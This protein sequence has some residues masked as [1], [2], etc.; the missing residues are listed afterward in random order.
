MEI[1]LFYS[2][3]TKDE[4]LR[5]EL[6]KA[7][8]MLKRLDSING[9]N[10]RAI[11]PGEDWD[12]EINKELENSDIILL[13]LSNDFL[14]SDYCYDVEVKK[15]LELHN[16][17]KAIAIPVIL[18]QCD[19]KH[20]NSPLKKLEAIPKD[21]VPVTLWSNPDIAFDDIAQSLKGV[22]KKIK[23]KKLKITPKTIEQEDLDTIH[24]AIELFAQET[25]RLS[26][27][28]SKEEFRNFET[29]K[30]KLY[31]QLIGEA[32]KKIDNIPALKDKLS[33]LLFEKIYT[34]EE[35]DP[36][37]TQE[38]LKFRNDRALYKWYER[39]VIVNAIALSIIAHKKF[40]RNKANLLIDF[41]SDFEDVVWQTA[42][43]GLILS[44]LYHQN[45]WQR[46]EDFKA[47]LQTLKEI[48]SVQEGL[49]DIEIIIRNGLFDKSI[50]N[51]NIYSHDFFKSP[52]NCFLPFYEN[53][54]VLQN[55][56]DSNITNI[57][58]D[59]FT[60]YV[61]NLPFLDCYKYMLCL[62]LEDGTTIE[63]KF[64][65][66]E[67]ATFFH[68]LK[69]AVIFDPFQNIISEYYYFLK[70]Y[71]V[72]K[73]DD[74]F[75]QNNSITKTQLKSIILNRTNELL[76][77]ANALIEDQNY[78]EAIVKLNSLLSIEP[79]NK[80]ALW[81]LSYCHLEK[82]KP[83]YREGLNLLQRLI[84]LDPENWKI[85][86]NIA[87][88]FGNLK[89]E[90]SAINEFNS[91]L[92]KYPKNET[93]IFE[94]GEF[95]TSIRQWEKARDCG[96]S[97]IDLNPENV[98]FYILLGSCFDMLNDPIS[99]NAYLTQAFSYINKNDEHLIHK[100]LVTNYLNLNNYEAALEHAKLSFKQNPKSDNAKMTLGRAYLLTKMDLK[101]ARKYLEQV[102]NKYQEDVVFGNLGHLELIE[103][104]R[105]K[106]IGFYKEC[107]KRFQSFR[108]FDK[109]DVDMP[110][111]TNIGVNKQEY[112]NVIDEMKAY[113]KQLQKK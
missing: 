53:N 79:L 8:I 43:A 110:L 81:K 35:L 34:S 10:F 51:S 65:A 80:E 52:S 107:V 38:I 75:K 14:A 13:L 63:R 109:F 58:P 102:K 72:N 83:D 30:R 106:A 66:V 59:K 64:D 94:A 108:D 7:L 33:D 97:G 37:T 17:E 93:I 22:I 91:L 95:F 47:R 24:K 98:D 112:L 55:A 76:F 31:N 92:N 2:Y 50:F 42:L 39:K 101:L 100:S 12:R 19:W 88:C 41:I 44:L 113:W 21:G 71:P 96:L 57:E 85:Q 111:M 90:L 26:Y 32:D 48:D 5:D 4:K 61:N 54:P 27:D 56:L 68:K 40:D 84:K 60:K 86:L 74:L 103:G 15:A 36:I 67:K 20:E 46:F 6:E 45:K 73:I 62:G 99:A 28:S 11:T 77:T 70:R 78:N 69:I 29:L 16:S 18:R 104:N 87:I 9:W 49:N 25:Q 3:S 105:E 23:E 82:K 89:D 1:N